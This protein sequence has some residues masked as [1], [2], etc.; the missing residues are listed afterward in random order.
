M[1]RQLADIYARWIDETGA[2]VPLTSYLRAEA[3]RLEAAQQGDRRAPDAVIGDLDVSAVMGP[4]KGQFWPN[5]NGP[6][7]D[8]SGKPE[9][10][11]AEDGTA[12]RHTDK[13]VGKVACCE[14]MRE[15]GTSPASPT[16][17]ARHP[18]S[19]G[20]VDL[21]CKRL[22]PLDHLLNER[23]SK[24]CIDASQALDE[25]QKDRDRLDRECDERNE[26]CGR[27]TVRAMK[28]ETEL[29]AV[30]KVVEA[31]RPIVHKMPSGD[32][33]FP[34]VGATL[35]QCSEFIESLEALD[36]AHPSAGSDG[37]TG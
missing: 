4:T 23:E 29:A 34:M 22:G 25:M 6:N 1:L 9:P 33:W 19:A 16:T 12:S 15:V 32:G 5:T 2:T 37:R 21:A 24:L 7:K 28:A 10:G 27:Q 36:A 8:G 35:A 20:L 14:E 11:G 26:E 13:L 30:R 31:A 3:T 17:E 18:L